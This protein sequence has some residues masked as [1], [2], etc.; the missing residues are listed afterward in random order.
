MFTSLAAQA[1]I[2][3]IVSACSFPLGALTAA[4]WKPKD[5]ALAFL[6]AFGGGTLLAALTIDLVGSALAKGHFSTLALE[7][8]TGELLFIGLNQGVNYG[9]DHRV[10][11]PGPF[12]LPNGSS[13]WTEG[14]KG[15]LDSNQ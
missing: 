14:S 10:G 15:Y 9:L 8:I 3:G 1:F 6:L 5:W 7:G 13:R 4:V 12:D 11:H 2:V